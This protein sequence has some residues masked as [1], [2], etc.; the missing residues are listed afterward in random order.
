MITI[1][2][3]AMI[4]INRIANRVFRRV[5]RLRKMIPT[6]SPVIEGRLAQPLVPQS[7]EIIDLL[8]SSFLVPW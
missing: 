1:N 6:S 5:T 7:I 3:I 8:H 2:R 4:T